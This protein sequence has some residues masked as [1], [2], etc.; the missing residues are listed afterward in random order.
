MWVSAG[1]ELELL[2]VE[3]TAEVIVLDFANLGI[4]GIRRFGM[5]TMCESGEQDVSEGRSSTI[6]SLLGIF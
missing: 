5:K 2:V 3:I 4:L 1:I 6:R